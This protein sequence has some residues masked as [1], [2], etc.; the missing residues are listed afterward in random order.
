M[1]P[2]SVRELGSRLGKRYGF[3]LI[4]SQNKHIE[5]P[6]VREGA[7][8]RLCKLQNPR[9]HRREAPTDRHVAK[10]CQCVSSSAGYALGS[11]PTRFTDL[12]YQ[13]VSNSGAKPESTISCWFR[14]RRLRKLPAERETATSFV[15]RPCVCLWWWGG[16]AR[17]RNRPS[18]NVKDTQ[19]GM[20]PAYL[21]Q[22]PE[23]T[24]ISILRPAVPFY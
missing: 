4:L 14:P 18:N 21:D 23:S 11:V 13:I 9:K 20:K 17:D 1:M 15:E 10:L 24:D 8:V 3:E 19:P 2:H 12:I 22:S 7:P 5:A 6:H 16:G